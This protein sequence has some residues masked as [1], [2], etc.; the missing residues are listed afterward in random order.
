MGTRLELEPAAAQARGA[1]R[2]KDEFLAMLSHELRNPLQRDRGWIRMLRTG[3]L[4]D[5]DRAAGARRRSIGTS[6]IRRS[7]S[8]DLLDISRIISGKLT[9]EMAVVNF[10]AVVASVV[11]TM[12]PSAE[13]K[14]IT[15]ACAAHAE[16]GAVDGD[17]ERLRTGR[18]RNLLSNAVKFICRA[19]AA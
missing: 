13:A 7:S 3:T 15:V 17:G 1:N 14:S 9:L 16:R 6:S 5:G 18:A 2:R 10:A 11:W 12:R 19:A 8:T 4:D